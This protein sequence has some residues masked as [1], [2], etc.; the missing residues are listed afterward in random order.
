MSEANLVNICSL[1]NNE[2][3]GGITEMV[4]GKK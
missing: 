1:S 3:E 4:I 2:K